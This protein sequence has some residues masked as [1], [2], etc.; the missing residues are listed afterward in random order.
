MIGLFPFVRLIFRVC[1]CVSVGG[2]CSVHY[3]HF[4]AHP[5][6][7]LFN[8]IVEHAQNTYTDA[9]DAITHYVHCTVHVIYEYASFVINNN[10]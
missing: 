7:T 1:V 10:A 6:Q 4:N 5:L 2:P 9:A 8:E 3:Q